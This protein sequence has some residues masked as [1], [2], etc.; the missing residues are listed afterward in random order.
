[1]QNLMT[2]LTKFLN[3]RE[4]SIKSLKNKITKNEEKIDKLKTKIKLKRG[5]YHKNDKNAQSNVEKRKKLKEEIVLWKA[6]IRKYKKEIKEHTYYKEKIQVMFKSKT[7]KTAMNRYNKLKNKIEELPKIIQEFIKKLGKKLKRAFEYTE[8]NKIPKTNN[9]I[10]LLFRTT[11]PGRIKR[12][13]RTYEGAKN[14]IKLNNI[15]WFERQVF[16][17]YTKN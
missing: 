9:L 3:K 5:R 15:R 17:K 14:K 2:P 10:E 11:F 8:N 16:S 12:I 1:M 13:F 4:R 7:L 6:Q